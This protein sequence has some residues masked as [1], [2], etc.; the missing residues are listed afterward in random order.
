MPPRSRRESPLEVREADA[1]VS[2]LPRAPGPTGTPFDIVAAATA[3]FAPPGPV[4]ML[5]FA[6]G[7][8]VAPLRA[9][10]V[11]GEVIG[12]DRDLR[13]VPLFRRVASSWAGRLR[14]V[15]AD[16]VSWARRARRGHLAAVID[17]LSVPYAGT[18]TKPEA[19][20]RVLPA[21]L[22]RLLVPRGVVVVN[23]LRRPGCNWSMLE[24]AALGER[25][26]GLIIEACTWENRVLL[27]GT[28]LPPAR[29]AGRWLRRALR[30]LESPLAEE[31]RL[32]TAARP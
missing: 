31:I 29:T 26:G 8:L 18:I 23:L 16:A 19:S 6:A 25:M 27:A 3:V 12:V 14:V 2:V 7:G 13:H 28:R 32:R 22:P 30:E 15:E 10:G 4:A 17:D 9:L 20:L 1:L 5:G 24:R 11:D 21:L